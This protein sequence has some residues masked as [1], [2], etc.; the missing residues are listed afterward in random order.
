M[1]VMTVLFVVKD[2]HLTAVRTCLYCLA[3]PLLQNPLGPVGIAINLTRTSHL[4]S[5]L[6]KIIDTYS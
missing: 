5:L 1:G 4:R 6:R 2:P 3:K